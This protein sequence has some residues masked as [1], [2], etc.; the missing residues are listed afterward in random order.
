[1]SAANTFKTLQRLVEW[2]K[3]VLQTH[4][5]VVTFL[6]GTL[7]C[8]SERNRGCILQCLSGHPGIRKHIADCIGLEFTKAKELRIL[9]SVVEVLPESMRN[10]RKEKQKKPRDDCTVYCGQFVKRRVAKEFGDVVYF[11]T[12]SSFKRDE[13]GDNVVW[14]VQYDDGDREEIDEKQMWEVLMIYDAFKHIET[15]G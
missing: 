5:A 3:D 15:F 4:S 11:G 8:T 6:F 9:R 14:S 12:I 10:G 1:M 13:D 7:P 2:S